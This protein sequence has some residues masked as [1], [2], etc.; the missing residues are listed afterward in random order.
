M[1]YQVVNGIGIIPE[2]VTKI[3]ASAFEGCTSLTRIVLEGVTE[4]DDYAFKGCTSLKA[5]NV[6]AMVRDFYI[7]HYQNIFIHV[8]WDS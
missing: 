6:P 8:S 7:Q 5:I 2:S 3:E 4:I 1:K